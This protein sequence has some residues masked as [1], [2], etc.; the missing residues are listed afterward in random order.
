MN[1]QGKHYTKVVTI[2][3]KP[4]LNKKPFNLG[5]IYQ[6]KLERQVHRE[7]EEIFSQLGVRPRTIRE[8][9]EMQYPALDVVQEKTV[10]K[11]KQKR[12]RK[13]IK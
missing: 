11:F 1:H 10:N 6:K 2:S 12:K 13:F 7:V 5:K 8:V 4:K 3:C 9:L